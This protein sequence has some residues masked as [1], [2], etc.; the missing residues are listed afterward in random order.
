MSRVFLDIS[1]SLD[2]FAAGPDISREHPLGRNGEALHAWLFGRNG[3]QPDDADR[4][5]AQEMFCETGAFIIGRTTYDV[6]VPEWGDDGAFGMPC[7]VMTHRLRA[8]HVMGPTTFTFAGEGPQAVLAKARA[9][10][11]RKAV[12]IMGGATTARQFIEAGLLDELRIHIAPVLLGQGTRLFDTL[13]DV[14]P[15]Q[16]MPAI[17]SP[18]AIHLRFNRQA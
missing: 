2:G 4:Q 13:R 18:L 12:C 16:A 6:G 15:L 11:G 7:F 9:E 14:A 1:L 17:S 10:A 3:Q 8:P 5:A